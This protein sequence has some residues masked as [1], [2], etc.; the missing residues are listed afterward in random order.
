M[1]IYIEMPSKKNL[2]TFEECVVV[3]LELYQQQF[4]KIKSTS[5]KILTNPSLT[6][7][8]KMK[9]F[10]N[11]KRLHVPETSQ[12]TDPENIINQFPSHN[13]FIVRQIMENFV[14][15]NKPLIDWNPDTF[16]IILDG[17][18]IPG[19]NFVNSMKSIL[20]S[21]QNNPKGTD[22]LR[23]RLVRIG[24]PREWLTQ[25]PENSK[26]NNH[27]FDQSNSS[28]DAINGEK[29]DKSRMKLWM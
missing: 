6:P 18:E 11:S 19:T 27:I 15:K 24:V 10:D 2:P 17:K 22:Y 9:L 3:P 4:R 28:T 26:S 21:S 7:D 25:T 16:E 20:A 12:E 8:L 5:E 23:D 1:F 29:R 13:Q 14:R